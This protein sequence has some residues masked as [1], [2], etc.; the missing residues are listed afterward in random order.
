MPVLIKNT[1]FLRLTGILTAKRQNPKIPEPIKEKKM[2][3]PGSQLWK[4]MSWDAPG[5]ERG[6]AEPQTR[7]A[8]VVTAARGSKPIHTPHVQVGILES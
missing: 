4:C 6:G 3:V 8:E 7:E 2:V 1:S 5:W